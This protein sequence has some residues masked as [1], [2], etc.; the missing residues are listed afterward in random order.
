MSYIN[1][2]KAVNRLFEKYKTRCPYELAECLGIEIFEYAFRRIRGLMFYLKERKIIG[3][4]EDLPA[5]EKLAIIAHEIGHEELHPTDAGYFF[6]KENTYFVPGKYEHEADL[7]AAMLLVDKS[8]EYGD[9]VG[10]YA[11]RKEIP[12]YLVETLWE[13][14]ENNILVSESIEDVSKPIKDWENL[15]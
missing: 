10:S 9:T 14:G 1:I 12:F 7:F 3:V 8:P 2:K 5:P 11:A 4:K 15:S 6:I 13:K